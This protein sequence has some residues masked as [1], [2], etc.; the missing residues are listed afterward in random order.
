MKELAALASRRHQYVGLVEHNR[1][2]S[3][4]EMQRLQNGSVHILHAAHP[5]CFVR[6]GFFSAADEFG[7]CC[8]EGLKQVCVG[9]ARVQ[10]KCKVTFL[11][12]NLRDWS[13]PVETEIGVWFGRVRRSWANLKFSVRPDKS[14][15]AQQDR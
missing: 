11:E 14:L 13:I 3:D 7:K 12:L 1:E 4:D 8:F 5:L 15:K 10:D 2:P 9:C 6:V